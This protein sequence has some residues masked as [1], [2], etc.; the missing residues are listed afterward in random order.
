MEGL[1]LVP[2]GVVVLLLP[3]GH[4]A[5]VRLWE[6]A[7]V[8]D[9]GTSTGLWLIN[10]SLKERCRKVLAAGMD[11]GIPRFQSEGQGAPCPGSRGP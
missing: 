10:V 1:P 4:R 9:M 6:A 8:S 2:W 5:I 7:A 3:L 11:A